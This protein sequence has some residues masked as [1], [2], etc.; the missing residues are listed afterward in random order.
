MFR[1]CRRVRAHSTMRC[2][3]GSTMLRRSQARLP[4]MVPRADFS[5]MGMDTTRACRQQGTT[6]V[7]PQRIRSP[8]R[9]R[10]RR[11][12]PCLR[13]T[14]RSQG[15]RQRHRRHHAPAGMAGTA[16]P[17]RHRP[18]RPGREGQAA[19]RTQKHSLT[20]C[21]PASCRAHPTACRMVAPCNWLPG[22]ARC[23]CSACHSSVCGLPKV[24]CIQ[25]STN[26]CPK[27][28]FFPSICC[29]AC[30]SGAATALALVM[31][32]GFAH[33]AAASSSERAS[34]NASAVVRAGSQLL[35]RHASVHSL[36]R[37]ELCDALARALLS[38]I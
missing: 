33:F 38:N 22:S 31:P 19:S 28:R 24:A 5:H 16:G 36:R 12:R 4:P 23:I 25:V 20:A 3:S 15:Q 9:R 8:A 21:W 2:C 37:R 14:S 17:R 10:R 11:H 1:A 27:G 34:R 32:L 35:R 13:R 7:L 30:T 6:A 29:A 26:A 18:V